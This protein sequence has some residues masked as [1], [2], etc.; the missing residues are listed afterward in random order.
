MKPILFNTEMVSAILDE[1][2]TVT[3][4][5]V[6]PHYRDNEMGYQII[7]N[8]NTGEYIRIEYYNEWEDVTRTMK[9][10]YRPGDIL[11][12]RETWQFLPC[13]DCQMQIEGCNKQ[14]VEYENSDMVAEGCYIYK[15][16]CLEPERMC[17]HPS[18]HM[19]KEAARIF[20]RVTGIEVQQVKAVTQ[21]DAIEEGFASRKEFVEAF[22]KMYKDCTEESWLWTIRLKKISKQEVTQ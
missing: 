9:E 3:R 20:L 22:F 16:D 13:I 4:R 14:P 12:V 2:K 21:K 19:P 1:R 5:L 6:K 10:P 11:Y 17:W 7:S 8:N 15:A 18:I